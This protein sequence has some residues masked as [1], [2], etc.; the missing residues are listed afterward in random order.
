MTPPAMSR[1]ARV[2][3]VGCGVIS[4]QYARNAP[5]F[6]SFQLVA[7]ADVDPDAA[8]RL[9]AEH[10]LVAAPLEAVLSDPAID[11]VLNLTPPLAHVDVTRQALVAGKHVYSEKPLATSLAAARQIAAAAAAAGVTV[12]CAPDTVLDRKSVV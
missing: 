10:G 7:C 8:D 1:P 11:I 2:G 12:C 9:A 6:D 4:D 3:I 5:A